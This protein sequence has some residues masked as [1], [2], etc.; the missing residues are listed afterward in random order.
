[1]EVE[2]HNV[3]VS[4]VDSRADLSIFKSELFHLLAV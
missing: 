2:M 4:S 3:L 1:M